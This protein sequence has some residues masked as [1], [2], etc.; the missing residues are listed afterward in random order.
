MEMHVASQGL[1]LQFDGGGARKGIVGIVAGI[2]GIEGIVVGMVGN[3]GS[4]VLGNGGNVDAGRV[5]SVGNGLAGN[6]GNVGF[7]REG[8][9]GTDGRG[10][11]VGLGR[12]GIVGSVSAGG[13]AAG[14][15]KSWRAARLISVLESNNIAM[16]IKRGKQYLEKA[17]VS[18]GGEQQGLRVGKWDEL[19][20]TWT[21]WYL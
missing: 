6:G 20:S 17:M 12:D 1:V 8:S 13:G 7:G 11:N 14:V 3:V 21:W 4:W 18:T 19:K 5:G 16:N 2:V 9:V 15:S 10:G